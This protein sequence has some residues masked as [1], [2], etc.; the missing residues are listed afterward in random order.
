MSPM[1]IRRFFGAS[2]RRSAGSESVSAVFFVVSDEE[3]LGDM[4]I[5]TGRAPAPYGVVEITRV[6][7]PYIRLVVVLPGAETRFGDPASAFERTVLGVATPF[8][9]RANASS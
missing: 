1:M 3:V 5:G 9:Q 4:K 6:E 7:I 8:V 2:I